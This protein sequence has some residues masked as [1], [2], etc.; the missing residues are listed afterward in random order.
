MENEEKDWTIHNENNAIDVP[1]DLMPIFNKIGMQL[2]FHTISGLPEVQAV[3]NMVWNAQKFFKEKYQPAPPPKPALPEFPLVFEAKSY[4]ITFYS[5]A[6]EIRYKKYDL[7]THIHPHGWFE[8][9]EQGIKLNLPD[10]LYKAH[11]LIEFYETWDKLDYKV[12]DF[13]FKCFFDYAHFKQLTEPKL[14]RL[15]KKHDRSSKISNKRST[16][17]CRRNEYQMAKYGYLNPKSPRLWLDNLKIDIFDWFT[18]PVYNF[19]RLQYTTLYRKLSHIL[20]K[21]FKLFKTK[22]QP[23]QIIRPDG[24]K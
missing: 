19:K 20:R 8:I 15:K 23:S 22:N 3:A 13:Y 14:I 11:I 17:V 21:I 5:Y 16:L 9:C 24:N 10:L 2:R 7:I 6:F 1:D 12:S 4:T 18:R